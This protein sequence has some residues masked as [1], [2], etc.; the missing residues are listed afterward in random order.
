MSKLSKHKLLELALDS[1][2]P[3]IKNTVDKLVF[4]LK[5]KYADDELA[6]MIDNY[7]FHHAAVLHFANDKE[8]SIAWRN[9][10]FAFISMDHQ[11]YQGKASDM[12]AGDKASHHY[13]KLDPNIAP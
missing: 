6:H 2:D 8:V 9:E 1:S 10:D 5:L 3:L 13:I 7:K 4:A 11:Y 12:V